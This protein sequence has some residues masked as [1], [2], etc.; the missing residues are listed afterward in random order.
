MRITR[1][2]RQLD[3]PPEIGAVVSLGVFDGVHLGHQAILAANVAKANELAAEPTVVTFSGHPKQVLLG[4]AP[5]TLTTLEHRL[6]L[7]E[8]AGIAH[9]VVL[10]FDEQVRSTPARV[11]A[12]EFLV[13]KLGARH[14]VFG[15][16]SKFGDGREGDADFLRGL[17]Y[18][19]T[20]VPMVVINKRGASSSAIREAV[21]LGDLE[22][23]RQMLGRRVSVLGEVVHGNELGR[24]LG[25]PTANLDL[26]HE[27]HPPVG[28][29]ACLANVLADQGET[30][31]TGT[32]KAVS[33]IGFRPTVE[34]TP[35]TLPLVEVHLFDFDGNLYGKRLELEFVQ[36]LR[37]ERKFSDLGALKA[38]IDKDAVAARG[39]LADIE[40]PAP[41]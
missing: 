39:V 5:R 16:D 40:L 20:V 37:G 13:A 11:F 10:P 14:F 9:T 34:G 38:Q 29:Y 25:F 41:G 32:W 27:L 8:R 12:E 28:V 33:N 15:F 22:G 2:R 36:A 30:K 18:P 35:P 7:F 1:D 19:T 31:V 4:R 23:A 24:Q 17:G 26:H 6:Q 21:E 3:A